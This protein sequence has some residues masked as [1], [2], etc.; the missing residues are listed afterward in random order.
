MMKV[1]HL[2]RGGAAGVGDRD[3][4]VDVLVRPVPQDFFGQMFAHAQPGLVHRDL[5]QD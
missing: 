1:R 3:H 5:I 4:Y 2:Q